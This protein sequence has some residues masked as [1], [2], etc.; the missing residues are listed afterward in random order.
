MKVLRTIS[1]ISFAILVLLSSTSFMV[2][3]HFCMGEIQEI[4]L[5]SKAE[6]CEMEKAL[7]PCHKHQKAAC[8]DDQIVFHEASD[9]KSSVENLEFTAPV[10]LLTSHQFILIAQIV[11]TNNAEEHFLRGYDP[12]LPDT[13]ITVKYCTFVI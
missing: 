8:C 4:A 11:P 9:F 2:G 13:D 5:F 10:A 12:P 1:A 6:G 7:P 3:L